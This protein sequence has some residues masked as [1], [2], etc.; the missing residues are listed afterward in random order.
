MEKLKQ[1][2]K[3]EKQKNKQN[4]GFLR[5]VFMFG[6]AVALFSTPFV[7]AFPQNTENYQNQERETSATTSEFSGRQSLQDLVEMSDYYWGERIYNP[8]LDLMMSQL[9]KYRE[10]SKKIIKKS[11]EE[12]NFSLLV[13]FLAQSQYVEG[14]NGYKVNFAGDL[15]KSIEEDT[16]DTKRPT[17]GLSIEQY[18]ELIEREKEKIIRYEGDIEVVGIAGETLE[19]KLISVPGI[20]ASVPVR[21]SSWGLPSIEDSLNS[22]IDES[23]GKI[24]RHE[25]TINYIENVV[26]ELENERSEIKRALEIA[27]AS[28][29]MLNQQRIIAYTRL[30]IVEILLDG[31]RTSGGRL[32][33]PKLGRLY[34]QGY[35]FQQNPEGQ[36]TLNGYYR[37][38]LGEM[39]FWEDILDS[40]E[41][42]TGPGYKPEIEQSANLVIGVLNNLGM[43]AKKFYPEE[44]LEQDPTY[45][46]F[47]RYYY[48]PV[49]ESPYQ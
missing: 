2:T 44:W 29:S 30:E 21:D 36:N 32:A 22:A 33:G 7:R 34:G 4:S 43:V 19:S 12:N 23:E 39:Q 18:K 47:E 15:I 28:G 3:S 16:K 49:E 6:L 41:S 9:E 37:A 13:K 31:H 11:E 48:H 20:K 35:Y 25:N 26:T 46:T 42:K 27:D 40:W 8:N 17:P 14:R 38:I 24:K 1:K 45:K 5:R 10:L